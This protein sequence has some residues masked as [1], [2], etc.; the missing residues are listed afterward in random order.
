MLLHVSKLKSIWFCILG[1]VVFEGIEYHDTRT[2]NK[3]SCDVGGGKL[4]KPKV[5]VDSPHVATINCPP[6]KTTHTAGKWQTTTKN[7]V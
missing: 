1:D 4:F 5:N 7:P 2:E 6:T 3:K